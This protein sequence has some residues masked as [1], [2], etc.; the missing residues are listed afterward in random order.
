[1]KFLQVNFFTEK[2]LEKGVITQRQV[3]VKGKNS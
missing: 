3:M 2:H 1:M